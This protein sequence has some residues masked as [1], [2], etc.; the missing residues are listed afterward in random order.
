[1]DLSTSI[2]QESGKSA[3]SSEFRALIRNLYAGMRLLA[4]RANA[5]E[6]VTV[7]V[8]QL[9]LLLGFYGFT[10]LIVSYGLTP[11]PMF[12]WFGLGYL[13]VELLIALLVGFIV[14]KLTHDPNDLL[15]FLVLAYCILPLFYLVSY[16][17]IP[18]LPEELSMLGYLM[19]GIWV[20]MAYF[21]SVLRLLRTKLKAA[22]VAAIWLIAAYPLTNWSL[23]FWYEG[24][25]FNQEIAA[26]SD[27]AFEEVNQE[28]VY[29]NQPILLNDALKGMRPGENGVTDL[30]F[31]GFGSDSAED[32][33]MKEVEHV[34][35]AVNARLGSTG[36]SMKLINNLK[37]IDAIPLAS[38]H[39]LKI[40]LHHLGKKINPDEDIV[41]LYLTGHGSADHTLLI[42]MQPLSLNDLTPQD[43]KAYLDDAGIRW[44]IIV[45][46]AC[47]SGGFIETLQNEH[48][49]ILTAAAPHKASFGCSNENEHTYFGEALRNSLGNQPF[50]YIPSFVQAMQAI[51]EREQSE[52]LIPS[53]PQL[54]VGNQMREKLKLLE[55]DMTRYAPERFDAL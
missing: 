32:V 50:Q 38:S 43:V 33:F 46:S 19:A 29:Y 41:F 51:G 35:H 27:D 28:E 54:F 48:S 18:I 17:L 23:S 24:Y 21:C 42:Q 55:H 40:S 15:K 5:V 3:P 34:H 4:L 1:M 14:T 16:A 53:E 7:S 47:Y 2:C 49:L 11:L 22:A 10:V 44:R 13:G 37:T 8:D 6:H 25:D 36:R 12:D 30:F 9:M 45:I 39:N 52:K 20:Y 31:I 26:Y